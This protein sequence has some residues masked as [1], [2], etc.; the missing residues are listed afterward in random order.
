MY[1]S[2]ASS[3][4]MPTKMSM[5]PRPYFRYLKY[6]ATA[7]RAKYIARR[8]N[9]AKILLV[10]TMKGSRLTENTA[11]MLSTA[12]ATSV[13]SMTMRATKRGVAFLVKSEELR[14][15]S[16]VSGISSL[17]KNL[18]P[19]ILSVT[20]KNF[21]NHLTKMFFEGSVSCSSSCPNMFP[22]E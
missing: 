10:S 11:G 7:A 4:L 5:K 19:C 16:L 1:S 6:F 9:I 13:V 17:M 20:G 3:I 8:P 15:K 21:L 22:P 18:S 2:I 12:K 14:V